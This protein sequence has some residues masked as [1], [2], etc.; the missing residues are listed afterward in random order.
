VRRS[1]GSARA[2]GDEAAGD[3][4]A[5]DEAAQCDSGG[6]AR[7][8]VEVGMGAGVGDGG[9][10]FQTRN[11]GGFGERG[12]FGCGCAELAGDVEDVSGASG[13]AEQSLAA[14]NGAGEDDVGEDVR[15][16]AAGEI[17]SGKRNAELATEGEEAGEEIVGPGS[18]EC[19]RK[20]EG[21]EGG[22][23]LSAHG[24]EVAESARERAMAGGGGGMPV[25]AK[26]NSLER[27][28]GRHDEVV[29][30]GRAEDGGVVPDAKIEVWKTL[31]PGE[32]GERADAV[33]LGN[34]I[35]I[36]AF[37]HDSARH[38]PLDAAGGMA[39]CNTRVALI[40]PAHFVR[41]TEAIY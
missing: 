24:G 8:R 4:A 2:G 5:G 3:E 35:V 38:P 19:R 30:G 9:R 33:A 1:D 31:A 32:G 36:A 25:A 14:G 10:E 27:K 17:A 23:R 28:V 18:G 34:C 29:V 6:D 39:F 26:V 20:S 15:A 11:A 16:G 22:E 40:L 12:K 21:E 37:F 41:L 7:L 13:R